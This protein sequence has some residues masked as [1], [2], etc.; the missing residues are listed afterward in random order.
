MPGLR[1]NTA[2]YH[3]AAHQ[4]DPY[5]WGWWQPSPSAWGRPGN[6]RGRTSMTKKYPCQIEPRSMQ[7]ALHVAWEARYMALR[8]R[9]W[10]GQS[11][12]PADDAARSVAR[13]TATAH[14]AEAD[15]IGFAAR[16]A[17]P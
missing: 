11:W 7:E 9:E 4:P 6:I 15:A 16:E 13:W 17:A 2:G 5:V 14:A 8:C 1:I 12:F 3:S 10:A